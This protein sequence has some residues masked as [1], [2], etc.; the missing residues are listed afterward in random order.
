[1]KNKS[2]GWIVVCSLC[3][4][5]EVVTVWNGTVHD[6]WPIFMG[7]VVFLINIEIVLFEITR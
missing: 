5:L 6:A 4:A 2:W 3:A 7:G 1:M